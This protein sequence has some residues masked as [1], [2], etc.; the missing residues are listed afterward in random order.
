MS[1]T[2]DETKH[3][4]RHKGKVVP[5]VTQVLQL[6][7]SFAGVPLDVLKAAQE[8][9][10]AVHLICQYWDEGDLDETTIHPS[11][12]G[13][14]N[15]WLKFMDE[16]NPRWTEIEKRAHHS[17]GFAGTW[18]RAGLI[19]GED[20]IV[21][22]KTSVASHPVWGIQTAAYCQLSGRP[23][24]RRGTVRLAKD[25]TYKFDTWTDPMDWPTF[26]S[27]ITLNNWRNKHGTK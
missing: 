8:R 26:V 10:T 21:D 7:H 4:Y 13:Y 19:K 11:L 6:L 5:S 9:G 24:A 14:F 3:E 27:L 16:M 12:R 22:I 25:G 1:L 18:D 2:F 20:W 15:A 17:L 23:N